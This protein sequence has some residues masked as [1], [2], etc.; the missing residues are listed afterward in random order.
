MNLQFK[1][2]F[3]TFMSIF[4]TLFFFLLYLLFFFSV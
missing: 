4:G 3:F 2:Y 1:E